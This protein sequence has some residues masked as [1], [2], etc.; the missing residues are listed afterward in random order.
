MPS[1]ADQ[2]LAAG[3]VSNLDAIQSED[4]KILTGKGAGKTFRGRMEVKPDFEL[5]TDLGKDARANRTLYITDGTPAENF[6]AQ[7]RIQTPS[8]KIWV[9]V[10]DPQDDYL[11]NAYDVKEWVPGKDS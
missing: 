9:I 4:I 6:T 10:Y 7:C 11:E 1:L 2:M 8:G 5:V 3:C